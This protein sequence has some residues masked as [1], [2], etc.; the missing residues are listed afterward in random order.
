MFIWGDHGVN[1]VW[2]WGC[3][4]A[5]DRLGLARRRRLSIF[6]FDEVTLGTGM[7]EAGTTYG[8]IVC[9]DPW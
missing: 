9:S 4:D 3:G 8:L 5:N 6:D 7:H 2:D 1:V